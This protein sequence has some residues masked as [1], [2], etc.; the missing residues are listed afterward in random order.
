MNEVAASV[1]ADDMLMNVV[2][3]PF[4]LC[5]VLSISL[6]LSIFNSIKVGFMWCFSA[7]WSPIWF[8]FFLSILLIDPPHD[9]INHSKNVRWKTYSFLTKLAISV[10][11]SNSWKGMFEVIYNYLNS[12]FA[13]FIAAVVDSCGDTMP[14][15]TSCNTYLNRTIGEAF[16]YTGFSGL[17]S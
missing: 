6:V 2:H 8:F 1:L 7:K 17:S 12:V 5:F 3:Q 9:V 13:M 10:I 14:N 4:V 11:C 15:F 16:F